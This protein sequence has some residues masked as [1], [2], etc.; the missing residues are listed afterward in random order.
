MAPLITRVCKRANLLIERLA[1]GTDELK[2][3]WCKICEEMQGKTINAEE[4]AE[5]R[6]LLKIV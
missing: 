3:S 4:E 6:N 1:S 2:T 5:V